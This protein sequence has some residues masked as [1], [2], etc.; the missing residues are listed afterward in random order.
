MAAVPFKKPVGKAAPATASRAV[1]MNPDD[2][3]ASGLHTDFDGVIK[4]AR[5]ALWNY[6]NGNGPK[7]DE[8]GNV[9]FG[10]FVK[11]VVVDKADG[12][13]YTNYWS[14]T[15]PDAFVPSEDGVNPSPVDPETGCA[16]GFFFVPAEG[17]TKSALGNN[18]NYAQALR[19]LRDAGYKGAFD[20]DVRFLEGASGHW[21]RVPQEKKGGTVRREE[22][23]A[24]ARKNDVLVMTRY[25][26]HEE[27][28]EAATAPT[29]NMA[30][31][32]AA[33]ARPTAQSGKAAPTVGG[34]LDDKLIPI[35][36]AALNPD[37]TTAI[38]K[39]ALTAKVM[40]AKGLTPA[41]KSKA[42]KRITDNAFLNSG[43]ETEPALW[44]FD[45][46]AGDLYA[47]SE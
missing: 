22:G 21:D 41:E 37:G 1:S 15:Y 31:K 20:S 30:A 2:F 9:V 32:K 18:T 25:D 3:V 11:V 40:A 19:A 10:S 33:P 35:V 36:Q 14:A 5:T 45:A 43:M 29:P 47:V 34:D 13:E 27:I 28:G 26:G 23:D 44:M 7:L 8:N 24:P 17:S 6:D 38:K 46:E 16:E 4:E 42:V 12:Q 39:A